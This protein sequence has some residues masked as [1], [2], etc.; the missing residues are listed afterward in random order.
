MWLKSFLESNQSTNYIIAHFFQVC[1]FDV[2][3]V[4]NVYT[5]NSLTPTT[6]LAKIFQD[7]DFSLLL[8][9]KVWGWGALL[10]VRF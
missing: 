4:L 10:K 8:G 5:L 2:C 9:I 3:Y 6:S 1:H 7:L